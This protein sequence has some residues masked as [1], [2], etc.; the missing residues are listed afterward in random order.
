MYLIG[1]MTLNINGLYFDDIITCTDVIET[2]LYSNLNRV[3]GENLLTT[4][5]VLRQNILDLPLPVYTDP[6]MQSVRRSRLPSLPP[7]TT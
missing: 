6:I 7:A 5:H 1:L 2:R 3:H 4:F